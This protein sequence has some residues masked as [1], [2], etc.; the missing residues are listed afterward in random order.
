MKAIGDSLRIKSAT[1]LSLPM[2]LHVI[3]FNHATGNRW[4]DPVSACS[5]R[6]EETPCMS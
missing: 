3:D 6:K 1:R 5:P 4:L 2:K